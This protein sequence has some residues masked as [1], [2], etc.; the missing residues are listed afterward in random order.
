M[1]AEYDDGFPWPPGSGRHK[2]CFYRFYKWECPPLLVR[3]PWTKSV[4]FFPNAVLTATPPVPPERCWQT[5]GWVQ[6]PLPDVRWS[7]SWRWRKHS[8]GAA[9]C[10][11][12]IGAHQTRGIMAAIHSTTKKETRTMS[13]NILIGMLVIYYRVL[14]L[15]SNA[16]AL[17][18]GEDIRVNSFHP[19]P[20]SQ[21]QYLWVNQ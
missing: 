3:V 15:Y 17:Q 21:Y 13:W 1:V 20:C 4:I 7:R 9:A 16:F 2:T 6:L 5:E 10:K 12:R 11:E 18:E 19:R 14:D 8:A